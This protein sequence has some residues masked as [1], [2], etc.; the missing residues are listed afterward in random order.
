MESRG[1]RGWCPLFLLMA[2]MFSLLRCC[3][4]IN[5]VMGCN[6]PDPQDSPSDQSWDGAGNSDAVGTF[7]LGQDSSS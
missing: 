1:F 2:L 6:F 3:S 7:V 5:A 4:C